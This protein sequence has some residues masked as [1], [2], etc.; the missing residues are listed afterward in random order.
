MD[1]LR[2]QAEAFGERLR[3][4]GVDVSVRRFPN[5]PHGFASM[6]VDPDARDATDEIA[7]AIKERI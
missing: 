6:L 5:L 4:S 3:K 7:D 1:V 2:D